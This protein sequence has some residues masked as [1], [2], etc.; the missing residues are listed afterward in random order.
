[1]WDKFHQIWI[2]CLL[3]LLA[4]CAMGGGSKPEIVKTLEALQDL[5]P[6]SIS[7][8]EFGTNDDGEQIVK[9]A[10]CARYGL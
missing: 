5:C 2:Y 7:K 4:G 6:S 3:A 8:V 9:S 1:M 10:T